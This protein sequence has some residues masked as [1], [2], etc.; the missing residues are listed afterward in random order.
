MA[1]EARLE[2]TEHGLVPQGGGWFVL[3]AQDAPW[4][5][6]AGRGLRCAFEGEP[7]FAQVG[8]S[9]Y[10]LAPGEPIGMYHWEADQEDFLVLDGD[11]LLL[12]EGEERPLRR[13]DLV[14]CPPGVRHIVLGAGDG[15]C[16]VLGLGARE[17]AAGAGWGGY[18]V[19]EVALARGAGVERETNEPDEAYARFPEPVPT[20]YRDGSLPGERSSL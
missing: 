10:V 14:H 15:P 11:A 4:R 7:G 5:D 2:R 12:V 1:S 8:I 18:P 9:L 19:D 20:S 16:V 3:N 13:W 17:H 6:R